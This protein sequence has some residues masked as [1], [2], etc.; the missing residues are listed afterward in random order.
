[1]TTIPHF[2]TEIPAALVYKDLPLQGWCLQQFPP[3]C[4]NNF[5]DTCSHKSKSGL[6]LQMWIIVGEYPNY[7]YNTTMI[8][9]D[10]FDLL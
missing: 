10:Y 5:G 3:I 7:I 1:M 9:P 6:S 2:A 8:S 4:E